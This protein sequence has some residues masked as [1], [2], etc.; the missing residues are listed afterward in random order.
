MKRS[1]LAAVF[2][3]VL[4]AAIA[5]VVGATPASAKWIIHNSSDVTQMSVPPGGTE[6]QTCPDRLR[7][8]TGWS[9]YVSP[10]ELPTYMPPAGAFSGVNYEVWKAPPGF[11]SFGQ[12]QTVRDPGGNVIGWNFTDA[13]GTYPATKVKDFTTA[14]RT[15]LPT[16]VPLI[17]PP[18]GVLVFTTAPIDE[19]LPGVVAGDVLGLKPTGGATL[20]TLTA[21]TCGSAP[22]DQTMAFGPLPDK[23]YGD[24][25]FD[26]SA[27]ASSGLPVSLAAAGVCSVSGTSV[28]MTGAGSCTITASQ[29]GNGSFNPAPDV[30]QSFTVAQAPLTITADNQ[31]KPY[32]AANPLLTASYSGFVNGD[33]P[34]AL[35]TPVSLST[36]AVTASSAGSYPIVASGAADADYS[37]TFVDGALTISPAT[38]TISFT[39]PGPGLVGGSVSPVATASSGLPVTVTVDASS[40]AGACVISA[41]GLVSFTG[42]GTCVLDANQSGNLNYGAAAQV[43]QTVPVTY[44]L[45]GFLWPPKAGLLKSGSTIAVIFTLRDARGSLSPTAGAALAAKGQ[46]QAVLSGPGASGPIVSS[47]VCAWYRSGG[48]GSFVCAIKTPKGLQT[49]SS[50]PYSITAQVLSGDKTA[51]VNASGAGNPETVYFR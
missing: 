44:A 18:N 38:Q 47:A 26:L 15:A 19:P 39:A 32:G 28:H 11:V 20:L 35:D 1:R 31:T 48:S 17:D 41:G 34:A 8:E 24:A 46:V 6:E 4:V 37:I 21:V 50:H 51:T 16:P 43:R 29:A 30:A 33:T 2:S 23:T 42:V 9:L 45:G 14:P 25:D 49:G 5:V 40:T 7:G 3:A 36:T 12:A 27:T 13:S 10:D 22:V